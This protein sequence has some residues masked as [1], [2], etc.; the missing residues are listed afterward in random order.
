MG[1]LTT[2]LSYKSSTLPILLKKV[3]SDGR[4]V[5]SDFFPTAAAD[6]DFWRARACDGWLTDAPRAA[7]IGA[8]CC[9]LLCCT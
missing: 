4:P 7:R 3:C 8:H 2:L 9:M 5:P 1:L 6:C